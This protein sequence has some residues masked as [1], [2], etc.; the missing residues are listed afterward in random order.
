MRERWAISLTLPILAA[1]C[2]TA[3][4]SIELAP[5]TARAGELREYYRGT[6]AEAMGNAFT[7]IADD[8][9]A[10][11]LNPAGLAG[12]DGF[13][14]NYAALDLATN[15]ETVTSYASVS[16][17]FKSLDGDS[18]NS[19]LGKDVYAQAQFTPSIVM[20]NFGIALL[21]DQQVA[22]STENAALPQVNFGFQTTDGVQAAY[23]VSLMRGRHRGQDFRIGIG[24][25]ILW[26][27]GGYR[28]LP[29]MTLV[30]ADIDAMKQAVGGFGGPAYGVDFGSQYI[31]KLSHNLTLSGALVYTDIGDTNFGNG[32]SPIKGN[33]SVGVAAKFGY[34]NAHL[35]LSAEQRH[36]LE[37]TDWRK[38]TH[39]GMELALPM[40]SLYGGIN[41]VYLTYGAS[42]DVW[43][44]RITAASYA[45]EL[46]SYVH[47]NAPRRYVIKIDLKFG[48]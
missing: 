7:A 32:P 43:I 14:F 19:I 37:E 35:T 44:M 31:R 1:F 5:R 29:M 15:W 34:H 22:L 16:D 12:V 26:R 24:G 39:V 41:Q 9:E 21:V 33:L 23:G 46:G 38:K 40:I 28:Q 18:F 45:E 36:L 20:P 11:F 8:E 13:R 10:I 17:A 42:F 2:S 47:Q 4:V 6:R 48:G 3:L 30:S 25:K 27:R